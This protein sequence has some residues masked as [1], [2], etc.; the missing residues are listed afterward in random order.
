MINECAN[1][2]SRRAWLRVLGWQAR[3]ALRRFGRRVR[4]L[5][6]LAWVVLVHLLAAFGTL[7]LVAYFAQRCGGM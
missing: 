5:A 1:G 6:Y 2:P 4:R 3:P 7:C